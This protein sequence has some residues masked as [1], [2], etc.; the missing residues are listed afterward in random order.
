MSAV[1]PAARL[2]RKRQARDEQVR[3]EFLTLYDQVRQKGRAEFTVF[4]KTLIYLAS[5]QNAVEFAKARKRLLV[6]VAK[7]PEGQRAHVLQL[8]ADWH[9]PEREVIRL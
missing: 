5:A 6:A 4:F 2:T 1:I 7:L 9:P 3:R 8:I